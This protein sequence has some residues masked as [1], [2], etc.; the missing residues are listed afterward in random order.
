MSPH[1][2]PANK[3]NKSKAKLLRVRVFKAIPVGDAVTSVLIRL[4]AGKNGPK[5]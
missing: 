3:V 4:P 2:D 1:T 5:T